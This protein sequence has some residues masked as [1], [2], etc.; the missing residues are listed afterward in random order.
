L[1]QGLIYN[2]VLY[3]ILCEC[4]KL[5]KAKEQ[6]SSQ[7]QREANRSDLGLCTYTVKTS[8]GIPC[9]HT[10]FKWLN[11]NGHI[12]PEDIHPFWWY[13]HLEIGTSLTVNVQTERVVLEPAVVCGKGRPKGAKG[14][15]SKNHGIISMTLS[16]KPSLVYTIL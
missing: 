3:L 1:V 4:A 6:A 13:K 5:Y 10:V 12:L 9:F 16:F 14:K 11:G 8:I 15:N 7:V 2:R